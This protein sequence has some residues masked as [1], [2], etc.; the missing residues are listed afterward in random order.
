MKER[1]VWPAALAVGLLALGL[2]LIL[3]SRVQ[4]QFDEWLGGWHANPALRWSGSLLVLGGE[5]W[6]NVRDYVASGQTVAWSA[7][8]EALQLFTGTSLVAVRLIAAG[9]GR[10]GRRR[11]SRS[12]AGSSR[13]APPRRSPPHFPPPSPDR[14]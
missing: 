2:R 13:A 5:F 7:R 1:P 8:V 12:R 6:S 4:M 11:S 9:E 10:W 3:I 14:G